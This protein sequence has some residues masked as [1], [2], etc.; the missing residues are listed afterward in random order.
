MIRNSRILSGGSY[1]ICVN[2]GPRGIPAGSILAFENVQVSGT[3]AAGLLL[4]DK[5]ANL[6]TTISDSVFTNNVRCALHRVR[7]ARPWQP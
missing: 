6:T 7:P 5:H 2:N 4:E 1:G 3:Q